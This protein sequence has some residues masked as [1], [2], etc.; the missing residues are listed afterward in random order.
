MMLD[1]MMHDHLGS[2]G[3]NA[4]GGSSFEMQSDTFADAMETNLL[5]AERAAAGRFAWLNN[6]G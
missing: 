6:Q 5:S 2:R 4:A 3:A 1:L